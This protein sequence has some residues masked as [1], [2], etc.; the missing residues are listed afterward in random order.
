MPTLNCPRCSRPLIIPEGGE[1]RP[2]Q[3]PACRSK[4]TLTRRTAAGAV[5]AAVPEVLAEPLPLPVP[6]PLQAS[7]GPRALALVAALALAVGLVVGGLVGHALSGKADGQ[8]VAAAAPPAAPPAAGKEAPGRPAQHPAVRG[9]ERDAPAPPALPKPQPPGPLSPPVEVDRAVRQE[10]DSQSYL[11]VSVRQRM[12][13][14]PNTAAAV[15]QRVQMAALGSVPYK[16]LEK[17]TLGWTHGK[18][19]RGNETWTLKV[20]VHWR[21]EGETRRFRATLLPA[22]KVAVAPL[23]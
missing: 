12:A 16:D 15:R 9:E 11:P 10:I 14:L 21:D 20:R 22:G 6:L 17:D 3:C 1:G 8:E 18:D 19:E 7:Y 23:D 5:F 4:V 13:R 2:F